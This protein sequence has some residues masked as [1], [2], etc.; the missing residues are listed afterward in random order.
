MSVDQYRRQVA[1]REKNIAGLQKQKSNAFE[2]AVKARKKALV[3]SIA[4]GRARSLSMRS[5]KLKE[6]QRYSGEEARAMKDVSDIEQK[7]A[8]ES[9]RLIQENQRLQQ[10]LGAEHRSRSKGKKSTWQNRRNCRTHR[11][12]HCSNMSVRCAACT[13][14]FLG[15]SS[16]MLKLRQN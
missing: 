2:K 10:A 1:Q 3:A 13:Q 5:M 4:A 14:D 11:K 7:I 9:T 12:G 16:S 15:M 6:V 8:A